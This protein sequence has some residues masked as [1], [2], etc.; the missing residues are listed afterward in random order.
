[1]YVSSYR[2]RA[3]CREGMRQ[4]RC[5]WLQAGRQVMPHLCRSLERVWNIWSWRFGD[6]GWQS[7][8][9]RY[10]RYATVAFALIF[11][12]FLPVA[13]KVA[14]VQ[15]F[16]V[17]NVTANNNYNHQR[18]ECIN[19][20]KRRGS[21]MLMIVNFNYFAHRCKRVIHMQYMNMALKPYKQRVYG[22]WEETLGGL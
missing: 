17:I 7:A 21:T 22:I 14:K 8:S 2:Q 15:N 11:F 4:Q 12:S 5:P 13:V 6:S 20:S 3:K 16:D 10:I 18:Y 9:W 19:S 1:M